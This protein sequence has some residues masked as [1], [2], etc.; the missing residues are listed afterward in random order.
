MNDNQGGAPAGEI[1]EHQGREYHIKP[2]IMSEKC[3]D[4]LKGVFLAEVRRG[5]K[6]LRDDRKSWETEDYQEAREKLLASTVC[7]GL[8]EA[9]KAMQTP[10]GMA[11]CLYHCCDGIETI[12]AAKQIVGECQ[13]LMSVFQSIGSALMEDLDAAKN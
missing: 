11:C 6:Q 2:L 1:F 12:D 7:P 10:S 3:Q 4:A 5:L 9:M 13:S 8:Q